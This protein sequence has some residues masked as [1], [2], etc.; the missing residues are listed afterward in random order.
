MIF[1]DDSF[2]F[3]DEDTSGSIRIMVFGDKNTTVLNWDKADVQSDLEA[4]VENFQKNL[5]VIGEDTAL[6]LGKNVAIFIN[7]INFIYKGIFIF[8]EDSNYPITVLSDEHHSPAAHVA[9]PIVNENGVFH[10]YVYPEIW[11]NYTSYEKLYNVHELSNINA[12][13]T[14]V[15]LG[16]AV[17]CVTFMIAL[18]VLS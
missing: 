8:Y 9:V 14:I 16:L 2:L 18:I 11:N 4:N 3:W 5:F 1:T 10:I 13:D 15:Q 6:A 12:A 7:D 17:P